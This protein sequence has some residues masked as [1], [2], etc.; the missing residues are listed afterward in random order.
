MI[1]VNDTVLLY[2]GSYCAV[3]HPDIAKCSPYKDFG[4]GFYLTTSKQQAERFVT[5]AVRKAIRLGLISQDA[6]HGYVS[7]YSFRLTSGL[8]VLEY[9]DADADWLHC[10]AAHRKEGA[11]QTVRKQLEV[12]DI[13]AG[14]IA[15]DQTNATLTAYLAE[16]FGALGSEEA[17]NACIARLLPERLQD[18][19]CLRTEAALSA[20]TFTEEEKIWLNNR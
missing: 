14:K 19:Y 2:H 3:P 15:N 8:R 12:Y 4:L 13:I 6:D 7:T 20:L 18:Q 10:V 17:D 5:A 1:G 11:F 16:L 9:R